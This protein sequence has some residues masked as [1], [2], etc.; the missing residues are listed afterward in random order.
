[1][2][3]PTASSL[4]LAARCPGSAA[5]ERVGHASEAADRGTVRHAA[6]DDCPERAVA[7]LA[8][9]GLLFPSLA[10]EPRQEAAYAWNVDSGLVRY[11]GRGRASY[12]AAAIGPREIAG[13]VDLIAAGVNEAL[14]VD[15]KFGRP[16]NVTPIADNYQ[17]GFAAVVAERPVVTAA[18]VFI[19]DG[20]NAWADQ[21][22][23][24]D[25]ALADWREKLRRVA[26]SVTKAHEAVAAGKAPHLTE[27]EHCRWCSAWNFCPAKT[28]L[29][30]WMVGDPAGVEDRLA[31]YT[32]DQ[33]AKAWHLIRAVKDATR[34][35]EDVLLGMARQEPIPLGDGRELREMVTTRREIDG[36]KAETVLTELSGPETARA[37]IERSVTQAAMK[38]V[39]PAAEFKRAMAALDEAGAISVRESR[40]VRE[41]NAK[42][43]A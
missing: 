28:Q 20:E 43:G 40:T 3:Q 32:P 36:D 13:T 8:E 7:L 2:R 31:Q 15:W 1:M 34:R 11:L 19:S 27:G 4:G 24:D 18:L 41:V 29:V 23:W 5:L 10:G 39:L 14:V 21:A 30:R 22:T 26:D 12:A 35:A 6:L 38:R 25:F 37:C 33:K 9:V 17:M 16:E 42:E